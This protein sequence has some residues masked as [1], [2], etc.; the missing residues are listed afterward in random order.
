MSRIFDALRQSELEQGRAFPLA[1]PAAPEEA[2]PALARALPLA[3]HPAPPPPAAIAPSGLAPARTVTAAPPQPERLAPLA[4][5]NALFGEKFRLLGMRIKHLRAQ[6][7]IRTLVVTSA[8]TA[9]GKS[10][11]AANLAAALARVTS[12]SVL[13]LDGDLR[14]PA[15]GRL[16]GLQELPGLVEAIHAHDVPAELSTY[17]IENLGIS[18]MPAGNL[19]PNAADALHDSRLGQVFATLKDAFDW[20]VVDAPPAIPVADTS[21]WAR[22]ADGVLLVVRS[23][24][25]PRKALRES[26]DALQGTNLVG[27]VMNEAVDPAHHQY[28][29][30]ARQV[31]TMK[32]TAEAGA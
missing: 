21:L 24:H 5:A 23:G 29:T 8:V 6:K 11:V 25:T 15:Q 30:Y 4:D 3:P 2:K 20:I 9:D 28:A 10:F 16:L 17:R 13:L 22:L 31:V 26:V 32:R 19:G 14:R 12:Q 18:V 1:P 27:V 7:G